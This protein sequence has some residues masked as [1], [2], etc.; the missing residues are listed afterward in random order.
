MCKHKSVKQILQK[1]NKQKPTQLPI[2][3]RAPTWTQSRPKHQPTREGRWTG[4]LATVRPH[5]GCS[6]TPGTTSRTPLALAVSSMRLGSVLGR[7]LNYLHQTDHRVVYKQGRS[8]PFNTHSFGAS[9]SLPLLYSLVLVV[10]CVQRQNLLGELVSL[11]EELL[12]YE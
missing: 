4:M 6:R 9:T 12:W 5:P 10:V 8:S 2:L 1:H 11:E 3:G 7:F